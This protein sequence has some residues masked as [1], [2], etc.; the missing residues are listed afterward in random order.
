MGGYW[1]CDTP[2]GALRIQR[3]LLA[4]KDCYVVLLDHDVL[5]TCES[6]EQG[7][8]MLTEEHAYKASCG[9][10]L[11]RLPIPRSLNGWTFAPAASDRT[12]N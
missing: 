3:T 9:L 7:L 10:D 4:Q 2:Q 6:A 12:A 5:G 1:L 8:K 11:A